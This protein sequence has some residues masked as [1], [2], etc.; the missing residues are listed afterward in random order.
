MFDSSRTTPLVLYLVG[1]ID[2]SARLECGHPGHSGLSGPPALSGHPEQSDHSG[3][4]GRP[5]LSVFRCASI[6]CT[7][8]RI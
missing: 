3:L 4:S 7:D 5:G 8:D 1:I 6:S 2:Q